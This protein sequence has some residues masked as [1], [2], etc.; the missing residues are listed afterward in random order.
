VIGF[1]TGAFCTQTEDFCSSDITHS[2]LFSVSYYKYPTVS[3]TMV[4]VDKVSCFIDEG[5]AGLLRVGKKEVF[6][7]F[8][9]FHKHL[10]F[11]SFFSDKRK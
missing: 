3:L 8:M 4:G 1:D 10:L 9:S 11:F 5:G 2:I 7:Q 6:F